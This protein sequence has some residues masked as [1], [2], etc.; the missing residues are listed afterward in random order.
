MTLRFMGRAAAGSVAAALLG[1]CLLLAL[2]LP[3][4]A[5]A[6]DGA[7]AAA[8]QSAPAAASPAPA[9]T[10]SSGTDSGPTAEQDRPQ[11]LFEAFAGDLQGRVT[12]WVVEAFNTTVLGVLVGI[13]D[14]LHRMVDAVLQSPFNVISR[15]PPALSYDSATVRG[16]WGI[17]RGVANAG[18][19]LVVAW[20]GIGIAVRQHVGASYHDA[21]ELLPRVA[22]GALLVNTSLWW[23]RLA[24]DTNNGLCDLLGRAALP[25]W[26]QSSGAAQVLVGVLAA[27]L[28]LVM[29][30]LLVL[31]QFMRLA[32]I[33]VLLVVAPVALL[34]WVLPQTQGWARLWS[35]TFTG[36]VFAQFVQ[37]VALR[38]GASL[39][40]ELAPD[41]VAAE[42][43]GLFL[44][45]AS[46]ALTLKLP[47]LI[48]ARAGDAG[49]FVR[50]LAY[51]TAARHVSGQGSGGGS[52][53][54]GGAGAGGKGGA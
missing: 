20:G 54:S 35:H 39:L 49:G 12:Q 37:V 3:T 6:E 27:L 5:R 10:A 8:P 45:V 47:G 24:I 42:L 26:E 19:V 38:L 43:V 30:V 52:G 21:A 44:G 13:T 50:Y 46:L 1:S 29:A 14:A 25:A 28:Y 31:Q 22:L 16:L 15:T 7:G 40:P 18:L 17:A 36:T 32:L 11:S 33:D 41:S 34:C 9:P 53:G 2:L 4:R 23:G 48:Q 51:R